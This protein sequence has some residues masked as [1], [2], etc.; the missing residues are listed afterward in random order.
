ME[1]KNVGKT[2]LRR[3][4]LLDFE[5]N[6]TP[7]SAVRQH[8]NFSRLIEKEKLFRRDIL[9]RKHSVIGLW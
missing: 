6:V 7:K 4:F 5:S 3:R 2:F 1:S 8:R 9:R